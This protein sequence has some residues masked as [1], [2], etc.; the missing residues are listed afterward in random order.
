MLNT[1]KHNR[2]YNYYPYLKLMRISRISNIFKTSC[3]TNTGKNVRFRQ[4]PHNVF[5]GL[6][7]KFRASAILETEFKLNKAKPN[8]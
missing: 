8:Y 4:I 6:I 7:N 3:N 5:T 1:R 2:Y